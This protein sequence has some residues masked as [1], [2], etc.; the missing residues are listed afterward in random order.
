MSVDL[1]R[2]PNAAPTATAAAQASPKGGG[3]RRAA[4]PPKEPKD[5][6]PSGRPKPK[7]DIDADSPYSKGQ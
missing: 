5:D 4:A 2:D 7:H 6:A 3:G 1:E